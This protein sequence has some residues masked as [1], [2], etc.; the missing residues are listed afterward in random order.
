VVY[1]EGFGF[2]MFTK[3]CTYLSMTSIDDVSVSDTCMNFEG[4]MPE[5]AS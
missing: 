4:K 2:A 3:G 1:K 5:A